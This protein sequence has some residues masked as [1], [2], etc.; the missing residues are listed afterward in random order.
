MQIHLH[1]MHVLPPC[2]KEHR[3]IKYKGLQNVHFVLIYTNLFTNT[4]KK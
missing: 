1:G 3:N 4:G 2:G